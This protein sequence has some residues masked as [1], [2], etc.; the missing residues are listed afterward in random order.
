MGEWELVEMGGLTLEE[1]EEE[2]MSIL[3]DSGGELTLNSKVPHF[4]ELFSMFDRDHNGSI[5]KGEMILVMKAF[6]A[7]DAVEQV[8]AFFFEVDSD[9][10]GEVD[11]KELI[12]FMGR[13]VR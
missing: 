2:V 12:K 1:I 13:Q 10:S 6:G 5:S 11:L 8:E 4:Q 7:P 3:R 9:Q